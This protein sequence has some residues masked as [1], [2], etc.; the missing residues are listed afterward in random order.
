MFSAIFS[1][2]ESGMHIRSL[3]LLMALFMNWSLQAVINIRVLVVTNVNNEW[4]GF[5]GHQSNVR[6]YNNG[7]TAF[8]QVFTA[9]PADKIARVVSVI[10]QQ[11]MTSF[12]LKYIEPYSIVIRFNNELISVV[13][14]KISSEQELSNISSKLTVSAPD[15]FHFNLYAWI[16]IAEIVNNEKIDLSGLRDKEHII[17]HWEGAL[18]IRDAQIDPQVKEILQQKWNS[19]ILPEFMPQ[20]PSK[21]KIPSQPALYNA[22]L[23]LKAKLE[24]LA[25]TLLQGEQKYEEPITEVQ[26]KEILAKEEPVKEQEKPINEQLKKEPSFWRNLFFG[27]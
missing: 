12:W 11:E 3:L 5:F 17:N 4:Y 22:L 16:P 20:V 21:K 14:V 6:D 9:E 2:K 27:D 15:N 18:I 10:L 19:V 1:A 24:T 8:K 7:W 25:S 13:K 23:D 26:A